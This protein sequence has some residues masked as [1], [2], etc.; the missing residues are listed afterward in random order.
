MGVS[1]HLS[2]KLRSQIGV[3]NGLGCSK[4][5]YVVLPKSGSGPKLGSKI[6]VQNQGPKSG[7]QS[8]CKIGVSN[9]GLKSWSKIGVQNQGPKWGFQIRVSN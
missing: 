2:L 7:S 3:P 1:N 6:R 8:G 9:R 5:A 4:P